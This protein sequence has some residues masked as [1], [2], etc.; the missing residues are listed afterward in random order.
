MKNPNKIIIILLLF[1][2]SAFS[3]S[4]LSK[5]S[6]FHIG[7]MKNEL[8][9]GAWIYY[10]SIGEAVQIC[11]YQN[12]TLVGECYLFRENK[13]RMRLIFKKGVLNGKAI[14]YSSSGDVIAIY[15]YH[16]GIRTEI[17]DYVID[18]D[19]PPRNHIYSP[20]DQVIN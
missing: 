10:N 13:L 9:D 8:K 7:Q 11:N 20:Y 5:D 3:Q 18:K 16:K 6:V 17:L 4:E 2:I 19:S 1:S 14:F 12:D 15:N